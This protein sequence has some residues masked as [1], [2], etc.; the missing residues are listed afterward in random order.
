MD[1]YS[2]F[3]LNGYANHKIC[4]KCGSIKTLVSGPHSLTC[5]L[6]GDFVICPPDCKGTGGCFP[7]PQKYICLKCEFKK[8]KLEK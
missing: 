1:W 4:S 2:N 3:E 7:Q 6:A 5:D 8:Y